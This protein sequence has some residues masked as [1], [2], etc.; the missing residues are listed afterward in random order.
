MTEKKHLNLSVH[1]LI[2][3]LLRAGDIDNRI[4]NQETMNLGSLIHSSFQ[5]KQGKEYLSEVHLET[6]IERDDYIVHLEGRAD[7]IIIGGA[8]PIIDEIKST[9]S[10]LEDF[11]EQQ[12][13]WHFGQAKCYAYMY[14]KEK[15]LPRCNIRLTYLSQQDFFTKLVKEKSFSLEQLE[16]NV[17]EI[18]DKYLSFEKESK[19]HFAIRNNSTINMVFPYKEFRKGQ[20]EAAKYVYSIAKKGGTFFFEA[21]TGIGKT[22]STIYPALKSFAKSSNSKIFYLT[23]KASGRQAC[24]DA[25][26]ECYKSGFKG[27][28]SILFAKDKICFCPDKKCNPDDCPYARNYYGKLRKI[29]EEESK[30]MH[31]Y[32]WNTVTDLAK[33]NEMCPFE[34]QLDLSFLS[35]VIICDYNYFFDPFVKLERYFSEEAD[36]S[37]YV[38]LI[39]EAHNLPSRARDMFSESISSKDIKDAKNSLKGLPFKKL[40]NSL[41][42]LLKSLESLKSKEKFVKYEKMDET[43][44]KNLSKFKELTSTKEEEEVS[45]PNEVR[46]LSRKTYRF[47]SLMDNYTQNAFLYSL[48]NDKGEIELHFQSLDPSPYLKEDIL[49]TKGV[50]IFSAT[51][52][53]IDY[54]M[55]SIVGNKNQAYL[56]LPSPFPKE[57]FHLMIAPNVSIRYKD[58]DKTYKDV[59][60]YLKAFVE[61]KIGNYFIY[62]PSYEY[63]NKIS[64]H[65]DFDDADVYSQEKEMTDME[66]NLFLSKFLPSPKKTTIGLLIIGGSFSEGIDL[67][68][69]RLIGVAVVGV[70]LPQISKEIDLSKEYFDAKNGE[71]FQYAYMNPGMNKVMQAVGRLIRSET[72]IGSALLIDERYTWKDYKSLFERRWPGYSVVFS[73]KDI[74]DSLSSFYRKKHK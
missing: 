34:L 74:E 28:D 70:G 64:E 48:E 31:R 20:K 2:D 9:V 18:V 60:K 56:A 63:L 11:Y 40:K 13:E 44:A 43:I 27:R 66:K 57:N 26:T 65:L 24:Y 69:D 10:P 22:I 45:F 62:F 42:K 30:E 50:A 3:F 36:P 6:E 39:D 5:K 25:L 73:A 67:P 37:N 68:S 47:L 72:D 8:N 51:F 58:R 55:E 15:N 38:I 23:A 33:K 19:K 4:Y 54:Y 71:G 49:R 59:A 21:P 35:D 7:G 61:G 12:K 32:N 52:S 53:P 41:S 46:D 14:L 17:L 16:K 29:I 1:Q